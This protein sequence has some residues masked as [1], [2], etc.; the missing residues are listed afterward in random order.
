MQ[1][2][3]AALEGK[4]AQLPW[5]AADVGEEEECKTADANLRSG[6]AFE[7]D[8]WFA[9]VC[10][11]SHFSEEGPEKVER[12]A[13]EARD[14]RH[15]QEKRFIA[16]EG[17]D[18]KARLEAMDKVLAHVA[19]ERAAQMKKELSH[20]AGDKIPLY[21]TGLYRADLDS[22]AWRG[23]CVPWSGENGH[24]EATKGALEQLSGRGKAFSPDAVEIVAD[25][26][27]DPDLF[28]WTDMAAHGQTPFSSDSAGVAAAQTKWVEF[29][30]RYISK[31]GEKCENNAEESVREALYWTGY[32][33]HAI[34]DVA[35]H[36]GRTN[37]EHS[38]NA[39]VEHKNPDVEGAAFKLAEDMAAKFL[40]TM[41]DTKLSKCMPHF[42]QYKGRQLSYVD[43][44][45][46][47]NLALELTPVE[48][49][50][51]RASHKLFAE[52]K[53]T[54]GSRVRWFGGLA[55]PQKCSDDPQCEQLWQRV[56]VP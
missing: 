36:R 39:Y 4:E 33:L 22:G 49:L 20:Y 2:G 51:Y 29:V 9:V 27:Q 12:F 30:R 44:V 6:A 14:F 41:L 38:Y 26:S 53:D 55:V 56:I 23:V 40:E 43:K 8:Y 11:T 13:R 1:E 28:A 35:P 21:V 52:I 7:D 46:G 16:I 5:T 24:Y 32:A 54:N 31:A 19:P 15:A 42:A 3:S 17:S 18:T 10:V 50:K 47:F 25:A 37:E 48:Y 34:E 45:K